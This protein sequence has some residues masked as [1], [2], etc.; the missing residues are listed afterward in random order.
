MAKELMFLCEQ[1]KKVVVFGHS[2][3]NSYIIKSLKKNG[4]KTTTKLY[5]NGY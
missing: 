5:G 3:M 1:H 2:L 4:W